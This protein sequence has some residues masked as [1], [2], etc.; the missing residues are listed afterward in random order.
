MKVRTHVT[1][2]KELLDYAKRAAKQLGVSMSAYVGLLIRIKRE[3]D[4]YHC[5]MFPVP[6]PMNLTTSCEKL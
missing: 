3:E 5:N 4:K 1:I 2:E 6:L